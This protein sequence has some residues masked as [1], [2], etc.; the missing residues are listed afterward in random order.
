MTTSFSIF[1]CI[2]T[3]TIGVI[4]CILILLMKKL[5]H[6]AKLIEEEVS[7]HEDIE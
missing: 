3:L 5:W 2:F 1:L 6:L 7:K 4:T